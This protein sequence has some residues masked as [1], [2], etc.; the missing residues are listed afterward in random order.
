MGGDVIIDCGCWERNTRNDYKNRAKVLG[1]DFQIH[2]MDVPHFELYRRLE[3]RNHTSPEDVFII[4]KAD[5]D[6]YITLFQPP[7]KDEFI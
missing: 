1:V 7:T 6:K 2:Y 3:I 5:M 4:S